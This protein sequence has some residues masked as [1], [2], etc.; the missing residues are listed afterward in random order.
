MFERYTPEVLR[1]AGPTFSGRYSRQRR[2]RVYLSMHQDPTSLL[3]HDR[4]TQEKSV[5]WKQTETWSET[6]E[7]FAGTTSSLCPSNEGGVDAMRII[8]LSPPV[9]S[10]KVTGLELRVVRIARG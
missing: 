7:R 10:W 2:G 8:N 9:K 3:L 4:G 5:R 1:E 6:C